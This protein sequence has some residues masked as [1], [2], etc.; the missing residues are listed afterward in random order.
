MD[1]IVLALRGQL[2][3]EVIVVPG[4]AAIVGVTGLLASLPL[5]R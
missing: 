3:P 2:S 1:Y 5:I 4:S